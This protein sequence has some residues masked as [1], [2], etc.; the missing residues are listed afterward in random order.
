MEEFRLLK[1]QK[2]EVFELIKASGLDPFNFKWGAED[3]LL[4]DGPIVDRLIYIN[5]PYFYQ[6]DVHKGSHYSFFSPGHQKN[7]EHGYP[8]SWAGQIVYFKNWLSYLKREIEQPDFWAEIER[9]RPSSEWEIRADLTNELF[10]V[11]QTNQIIA[12]INQIRD[13][14]LQQ[15]ATDMEQSK[16]INERLDYLMASVNRLGRRDWFHTAIG[17]FTTIMIGLAMS[18]EQARTI[19]GFLRNALAGVIQFLP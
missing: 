6:F 3:S 7:V 15:I 9:F 13:Y 12:G 8:G 14:L 1:S 16:L 17:V 10:S 4:P 19:W 11:I 5:S 18:P 2:N